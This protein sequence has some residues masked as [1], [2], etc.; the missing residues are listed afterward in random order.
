MQILKTVKVVGEV[1]QRDGCN[2]LEKLNKN[3]RKSLRKKTNAMIFGEN[4]KLCLPVFG[5]Q[6]LEMQDT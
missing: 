4:A 1:R 2:K 5:M 3:F 6:F